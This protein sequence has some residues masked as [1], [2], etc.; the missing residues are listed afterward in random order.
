MRKR[1]RPIPAIVVVLAVAAAALAGCTG[2]SGSPV[3]IGDPPAGPSMDVVT[4]APGPTP[5]SHRS[6]TQWP[7]TDTA[8]TL[9]VDR[10]PTAADSLAGAAAE[11]AIPLANIKSANSGDTGNPPGPALAGAVVWKTTGQERSSERPSDIRPRHRHVPHLPPPH[12]QDHEEPG[13]TAPPPSD[14]RT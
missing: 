9:P 3:G 14:A 8:R 4:T 1:C 6:P 7:R 10:A 13:V 2:R 12:D 11:L 5:P